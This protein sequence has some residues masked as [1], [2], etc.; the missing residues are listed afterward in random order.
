MGMSGCRRLKHWGSSPQCHPVPPTTTTS[1][2]ALASGAHRS[3]VPA[4][5]AAPVRPNRRTSM[6]LFIKRS[7]TP[8]FQAAHC[9]RHGRCPEHANEVAGRGGL[10]IYF[11]KL[12]GSSDFCTHT[13]DTTAYSDHNFDIHHTAQEPAMNTTK[14]AAIA[15]LIFLGANSAG[16]ANTPA[17]IDEG[18]RDGRGCRHRGSAGPSFHGGNRRHRQGARPPLQWRK[19]LSRRRPPSWN[20]LW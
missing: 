11:H 20:K 3:A 5:T 8:L 12:E 18:F 10:R 14:T 19:L 1:S 7:P 15:T 4:A 16:A 17:W 9:T 6:F 2:C 13:L